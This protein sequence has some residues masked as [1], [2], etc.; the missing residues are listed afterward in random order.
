[1]KGLTISRA[2]EQAGVGVETI[3]FYERKGLVDQPPKPE[4]SS[5]RTY[6]AETIARIRFIRQA[7]QL[8]FSLRDVG[9]LI[10]LRADPGADAADVRARAT[11]KL[12]DVT[13][14]IS[15][16]Q[17]VRRAL[18]RLIDACPGRGELGDCSIMEALGGEAPATAGRKVSD[19]ARGRKRR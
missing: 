17:D 14:K 10:S 2:A 6:P 3:R 12:A 9:D 7:Q 19:D 4:G 15:R 8:G 11:A 13:D 18:E 5:Y 1:M 16:L